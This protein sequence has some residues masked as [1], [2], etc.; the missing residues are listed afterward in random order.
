MNVRRSPLLL[1]SAALIGWCTWAHGTSAAGA[2]KCT[3]LVTLLVGVCGLCSWGTRRCT[4]LAV[5]QQERSRACALR[6]GGG[7]GRSRC[8]TL[9]VGVC[10]LCRRGARSAQARDIS[11]LPRHQRRLLGARGAQ[12][13]CTSYT[14]SAQAARPPLALCTFGAQVHRPISAMEQSVHVTSSN[15]LPRCSQGHPPSVYSAHLDVMNWNVS[16]KSL[17]HPSFLVTRPQ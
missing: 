3:T 13:P 6:A 5:G 8:T 17:S 12:A 16:M 14:P 1:R 4:A 7:L 15:V 10:G 2:P 9:K 11:K